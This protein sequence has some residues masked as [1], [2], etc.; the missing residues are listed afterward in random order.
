MRDDVRPE[1]ADVAAGPVM[2][3]ALGFLAFVALSVAGLLLYFHLT[4]TGSTAVPPHAFPAPGLQGDPRAER[5]RLEARQSAELHGYAWVDR[6][7]G[8]AH[9]PIEDAMALVAARGQGAFDPLDAPAPG[10]PAGAGP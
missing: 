2:W 9:I 8:L 7:A 5:L 1:P 10:A 6:A 3:V 4:V